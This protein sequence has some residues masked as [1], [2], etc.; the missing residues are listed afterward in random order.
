MAP[1]EYDECNECGGD[2]EQFGGCGTCDS[3]GEP[4]FESI[5]Q[6]KHDRAEADFNAK[7]PR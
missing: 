5:M 2:P 1:E 6:A 4:D 7:W 3:P